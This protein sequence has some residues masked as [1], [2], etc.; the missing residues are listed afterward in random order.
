[1]LQK[2][3]VSR[4]KEFKNKFK[5]NFE[6]VIEE[7]NNGESF[8]KFINANNK[9]SNRYTYLPNEYFYYND[10]NDINTLFEKLD[11]KYNIIGFINY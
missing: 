7:D 1:M 9:I 3:F 6:I 2:L 4:Y 5:E 8:I 11:K 10:E